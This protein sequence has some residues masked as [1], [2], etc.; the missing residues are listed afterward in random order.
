MFTDEKW[1]CWLDQELKNYIKEIDIESGRKKKKFLK[2][3]YIHFD[4]KIWLPDRKDEIK[5]ILSNDRSVAKRAFYPFIRTLVKSPRYRYN[6]KKGKRALEYKVRPICYASHIDSLIYSFYGYC[7][8]EKYQEYIKKIKI[9]KSVLAYRTDLG[10]CN[11]DFANEVFKIIKRRKKCTAIA[12]D[13]KGFFDNL[14]HK[15]LKENWKKVMG[16]DELPNDQFKIYK[17]LCNYAYVNKNT[18]LGYLDI[19]LKRVSPK[20]KVF[21]EPTAQNFKSLRERNIIVTNK[22]PFGIPQ[23][24]GISGVLSNIYM[25]GFDK[26]MLRLSRKM[27]FL[28]FR[29]CDDILIICDSP[30]ANIIAHYAYLKIKDYKLVIQKQK[31]DKIAFRR[32]GGRLWA[33]DANKLNKYKYLSPPPKQRDKFKKNLQY[34]GFE[35]DGG[36][37]LI[38]SSTLSRY[39]RRMTSRIHTTLRMAYGKR[40]RGN[41]VFIRKLL[42]RST[43]LGKNNFISY[44]FRAAVENNIEIKNQLKKHNKN[45]YNL[46]IRKNREMAAIRRTSEKKL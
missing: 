11:I 8:N 43:H 10:K 18:L 12:L 29:Y 30:K 17:S 21:F 44:G 46:L 6:E 15:I 24:S 35:F 23:G 28:Y 25:I 19:D 5:N 4:P 45:F 3:G 22:F 33:F 26:Y 39:Y 40:G 31:E 41:K 42:N 7:L 37:T 27:N 32:L 20:P 34:L 1:N 38:R 16:L 36:K 13:I 9:D 2:K 14:D